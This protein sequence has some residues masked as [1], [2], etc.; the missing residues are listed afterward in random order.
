MT[1]LLLLIEDKIKLTRLEMSVCTYH[2]NLTDTHFELGG[3]QGTRFEL[4]G[5]QGLT[6]KA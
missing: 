5:K 3:K 6:H 4:D 1:P 2:V